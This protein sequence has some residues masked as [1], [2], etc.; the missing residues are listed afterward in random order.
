M[1]ESSTN[2]S[3]LNMDPAEAEKFD[4]LASRWWDPEGDFRPLHDINGPRADYIAARCQLRGAKLI[5]I[6]CGGGLLCEALAR[7]GAEVTG[8]DAAQRPLSVARLHRLESELEIDY[9]HSTAEEMADQHADAFDVVCC[10]EMLEH[11]PDPA[12]T[13]KAC[14]DLVRPGGQLFFSTI[15]RTPLAWAGAI[16]GAEYVLGL[17]P[18]GTHRYDRLI[19][20]AELAD[21]CRRAGLVVN[22]I[23]GMNYNPFSRTVRIGGRP[24]INYLLH[25]HRP[26][27]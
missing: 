7:R 25:A 18:R 6:G 19:R 22:E 13:I 15:N 27:A 20:P 8:L 9:V 3:T 26:E 24:S 16:V 23:V 12:S 10:L 5:D 11:V 14:A 4:A 1:N 21:A 17:L 2:Q